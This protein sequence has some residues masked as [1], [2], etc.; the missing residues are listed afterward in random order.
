M[1]YVSPVYPA[2][3]WE[4]YDIVILYYLLTRPGKLVNTDVSDHVI[5]Y[6][7]LRVA[8]TLSTKLAASKSFECDLPVLCCS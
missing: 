5:E 6:A 4:H 3:F 2:G 7:S 8:D 1:F